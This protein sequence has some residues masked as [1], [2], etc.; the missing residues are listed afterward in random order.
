MSRV[1]LPF[2]MHD[3]LVLGKLVDTGETDESDETVEPPAVLESAAV[4]SFAVLSPRAGVVVDTLSSDVVSNVGLVPA[5]S[6]VLSVMTGAV[7][8][9][10]TAATWKRLC[11]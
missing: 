3:G 6:V 2:A 5:L 7:D 11:L 10:A 1:T 9:T 4:V 8:E